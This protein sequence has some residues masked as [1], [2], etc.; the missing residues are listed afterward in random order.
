[1][2]EAF[3]EKAAAAGLVDRHLE[4]VTSCT[5]TSQ[6]TLEFCNIKSH[7]RFSLFKKYKIIFQNYLYYK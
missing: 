5:T 4:Q 7:Y 6:S 3:S 2:N 1:M